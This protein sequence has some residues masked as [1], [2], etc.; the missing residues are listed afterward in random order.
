MLPIELL[1]AEPNRTLGRT[2]RFLGLPP[3]PGLDASRRF[4]IESPRAA[5]PW[6][7]PARRAAGVAALPGVG[8]CGASRAHLAGG[9]APA[10]G[11]DDAHSDAHSGGPRGGRSDG[12]SCG[13]TPEPGQRWLPRDE[14]VSGRIWDESMR[15]FA[16]S[17]AELREWLLERGDAAGASIVHAWASS[18]APTISTIRV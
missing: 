12:H 16:P 6:L 8:A 11:G 14:P 7:T 5:M 1:E 2:F 17:I 3:V 18:S 9:D 13:V 4:C 10:D 15:F